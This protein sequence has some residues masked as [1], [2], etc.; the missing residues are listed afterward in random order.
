MKIFKTKL[1]LKSKKNKKISKLKSKKPTQK[2]KNTKT[3]L[4][5]S[6]IELLNRKNIKLKDKLKKNLT[7]TFREKMK[8]YNNYLEGLNTQFD[9]PKI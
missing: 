9:I 8:K 5:K 3:K 7:L 1:I 4:T 2:P 6:Q